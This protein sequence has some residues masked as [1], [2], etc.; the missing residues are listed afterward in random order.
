MTDN[1][2]RELAKVTGKVDFIM[3]RGSFP[4][5]ILCFEYESGFSQCLGGNFIDISFLMRLCKCFGVEKLRDIEGKSCWVWATPSNILRIDPLH[6]KDGT[7]FDI[8]EW[9][10]WREKNMPSMTSA[11]LLGETEDKEG[12]TAE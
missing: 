9:R 6:S 1:V 10:A 3:G 8:E 7:P 2:K 5:V 12:T 11:E 4:D